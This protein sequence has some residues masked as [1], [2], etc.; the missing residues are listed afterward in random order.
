MTPE[1]T[2]SQASMSVLDHL[3]ELRSR[4]IRIAVVFAAA[5]ALCWMVSDRLA[6]WALKPV[7]QYLFSGGEIVFTQPTEPFVIY[8]K[9]SAMAAV[10]LITPYLLWHVWR[11]VAPG[12][13]PR[14]R[15]MIAPF[16]ILGTLFFVSGGAF[17]Y[18]VATPVAARWLLALGQDFKPMIT[19]ESGFQFASRIILGM[20]VVFVLLVVF[21]F[22]ARAGVVSARG[23][24]RQLR[25]AILAIAVIAAVI[26]P[27]GDIMTMSVF[28]GPMILLYLLGVAMAWIANPK[29]E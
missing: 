26:T 3:D 18:Y 8:M 9:I 11:F 1:S 19:L 4:L 21:L 12:L 20:G 25:V 14:E 24:L 6:V 2:D 5:V 29:G 7:R 15:W 13:Y 27:T 28:A 16:M 17:G 10:F 23:L 22:L